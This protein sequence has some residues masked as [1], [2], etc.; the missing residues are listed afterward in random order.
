MNIIF[1]TEDGTIPKSSVLLHGCNYEPALG[2][3]PFGRLDISSISTQSAMKDSDI[4]EIEIYKDR[5]MT[6]LIA[7]LADGVYISGGSLEPGNLINVSM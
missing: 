7:V 4:F 3:T 2:K 6:K 5:E 1:R